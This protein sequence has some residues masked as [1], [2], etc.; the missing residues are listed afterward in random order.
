MVHRKHIKWGAQA[1]LSPWYD[2]DSE[3]KF[4]QEDLILEQ[5]LA[6]FQQSKKNRGDEEDFQRTYRVMELC[7]QFCIQ[8]KIF[9][10]Y[11]S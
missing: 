9:R 7:I 3:K 6:Y 2:K 11:S 10:K 8:S 1:S 4:I 5:H